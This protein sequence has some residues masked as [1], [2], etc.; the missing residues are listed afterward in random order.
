MRL[1]DASTIVGEGRRRML[2]R[3]N[4]PS[5]IGGAGME[6]EGHSKE[7]KDDLMFVCQGR[8]K[9]SSLTEEQSLY[10]TRGLPT[11]QKSRQRDEAA[12]R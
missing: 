1:A 9:N 7:L 5:S 6:V 4:D 8:S 2:E 3:T 10:A 12:R 11:N